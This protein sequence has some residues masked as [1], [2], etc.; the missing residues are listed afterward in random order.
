MEK[1]LVPKIEKV[2]PKNWIANTLTVYFDIGHPSYLVGLTPD[3]G[4]YKFHRSYLTENFSETL[5]RYGDEFFTQHPLNLYISS[6]ENKLE[7]FQTQL[8]ENIKTKGNRKVIKN[9]PLTRRLRSDKSLYLVRLTH[10]Y[11]IRRRP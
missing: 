1:Q 3:N 11:E 4:F 8:N 9:M 5:K 2:L 10:A 6:L 7:T